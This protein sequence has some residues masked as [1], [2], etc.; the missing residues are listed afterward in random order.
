MADLGLLRHAHLRSEGGVRHPL[1]AGAGSSLGKHLIDLLEGKTL[2]LRNED[3]GIDEGAGAQAAPDEEHLGAEVALVGVDHVGGD[4]GD[5]AV[6]QPVGGGREGDTL[7]AHGEGED[8]TDDNPCARAP[9]GSEEEDVDADEG[10]HNLDG[11]VRV[12]RD[13]TDDGHD[14]LADA[15][16]QGTPDEEGAAAETLHGP[17]GEWGRAH[18][19]E[20]GDHGDE[21]GVVDGA[22]L[23]EEGGSEV[24]DEVDARPLLH[25][26]H[27]G[28][29]NRAA[30]VAAAVPEGAAEAVGPGV[31]EVALGYE[32]HLV[33]VVGDDLG[34]LVLNVG[35]LQGLVAK[36]GKGLGG[37][38]ELALAHE[39]A[40]GLGEEEQAGSEDD[41]PEHLQADGNAVRAGVG[42]VLGA[43][44]D[45]GR[46]EEAEADAEL[47][48]G[49]DGAADLARGDLRHV[50]DDDGRDVTDAEAGN[51]AAGHDETE[52]G[53]CGLEDDADD[54]DHAADD[55]GEAT[56]EP[57]GDVAGHESTEEGSGREDRGN[58]RLVRRSER[59]GAATFDHL[60]EDLH[61]HHTRDVSGVVAEEDTAE[62]REDAHHVGLH[63]HRGFDPRDISLSRASG[64]TR[65]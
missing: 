40:G 9:G 52:A 2:G 62:G 50:Q 42:A 1:G 8:F 15:H 61:A 64:L 19:D 26:L 12:G 28:A 23:H 17:E 21:E 48:S 11:D 13:G 38:I 33:L 36:A 25:H 65:R 37:L 14:I 4:D 54:K 60:D 22:E 18:V 20:G 43:V 3:I 41:S 51:E 16:A 35:G 57:I 44:V 10:D 29:E 39:E 63:G 47:V 58:E 56:A 46:E 6:P 30:Q 24:E 32:G 55:D 59:G 31:E 5:D 49:H 53:G 27:R 7:G 45:A 34:E